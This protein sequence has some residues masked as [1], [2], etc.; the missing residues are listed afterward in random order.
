M[1]AIQIV[2]GVAQCVSLYEALPTWDRRVRD[3]G[4]RSHQQQEQHMKRF[5][6]WPRPKPLVQINREEV[7]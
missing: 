7:R 1:K 3:P 2:N 4:S 5:V 6:D